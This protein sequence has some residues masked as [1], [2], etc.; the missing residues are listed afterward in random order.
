MHQTIK[1]KS[2]RVLTLPTDEEEVLINAGISADP[3]TFELTDEQFSQLKPVKMG[4]PFSE[5]TK[6]SITIR[7]SP[8]VLSAFRATGAGWQTRIDAALKEWLSQHPELING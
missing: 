4:R 3:D 6:E 2:G 5:Q 7:L 1:T 8:E